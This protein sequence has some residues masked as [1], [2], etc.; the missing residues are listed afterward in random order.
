MQP[1]QRLVAAG[2]A[3]IAFTLCSHA[4]AASNVT[5]TDAGDGTINDSLCTLR[6]AIIAANSQQSFDGCLFSGSGSPT[7]I[8]FAIGS[9][10]QTINV[11]SQLPP[12]AVPVVIDGL[13]QPG[14]SCA[15]WPPTLAIQ[16][17]SPTNGQY[18]GLTLNAGSGGSTIRGLVIN[19]FNNNQG[20]AYNFNAAINILSSGNRVE[21]NFLGVQADGSTVAPNLRGVDINGSSN[22][23][24]GSDGT[25]KAYFARNLISGNSYGQVDTRGNALS[26]NR[27]SGNYIGT[28][29]SGS[30]AMGNQGGADGV[31]INAN[32]GPAT[33]NYVGWDGVGDPALMRNVISGFTGSTMAGVG[34]TVGAQNNIVAGNYIGTDATGTHPIGNFFG[35]SLGSNSSIF[36]N[37]IGSD[38]NLDRIKAR[39][40]ISG[41]TFTGVDINAA[42]GTHD[43]A[44]I[45]NYIGVDAAGKPLGNGQYGISMDYSGANTLVNGNWIAGQGTAI[46]FFGSGSFG[47][48]AT[49]AFI[50]NSGNGTAGLPV[51]DSRD[52]C[53]LGGTGVLVYA[54]GANV[55]NPNHF[56]NNWWGAGSGPNT[57]GASSADGSI[58]ATPWLA[59]PATVCSD[60]IFRN[61][62][63]A[64]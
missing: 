29:A 24:I 15:A 34:M 62:F 16:I 43:N 4:R 41:N 35:V 30:V 39:N 61:G 5:I 3:V 14:A 50:N 32:P 40:V 45:G 21:C 9:G 2:V 19:G 37:V 28:D 8:S 13:T 63:Q 31:D 23:F 59:F 56:E 44:V 58:A 33:G 55:P 42:N 25:A 12:I 17:T 18:N 11:G 64:P 26:G 1:F 10:L 48:G 38:G 20:Y 51:L 46:R 49:A 54:Q 7:T 6:E 53:V 60:V 22:N 36:H 52:N 57:A 47:G 27:I